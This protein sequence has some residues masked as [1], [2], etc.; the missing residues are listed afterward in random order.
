MPNPR[1]NG[2]AS[3][4][5]PHDDRERERERDQNTLIDKSNNLSSFVSRDMLLIL[6]LHFAHDCYHPRTQVYFAADPIIF[7]T[8][9]LAFVQ[10]T[11]K[12][13]RIRGRSPLPLSIVLTELSRNNISKIGFQYNSY[14]CSVMM[15][16][17]AQ[18]VICAILR[19]CSVL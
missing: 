4:R 7:D 17:S 13:G 1:P 18:F 5:E 11:A 16:P 9:V 12:V 15:R 14:F 10:N 2:G 6:V 19:M 8:T 3:K